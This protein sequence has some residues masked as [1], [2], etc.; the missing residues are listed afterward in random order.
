MAKL[1]GERLAEGDEQGGEQPAGEENSRWGVGWPAGRG[2]AAELPSAL[3]LAG[4]RAG[5]EEGG[6]W[7]NFLRRTLPLKMACGLA[8]GGGRPSGS[9]LF[10]HGSRTAR[11][12]LPP[13]AKNRRARS[14]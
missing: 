2:A 13:P 1:A 4:S 11:R 6:R 8:W 12:A 14:R 7:L 9:S 10:P 5:G 3:A